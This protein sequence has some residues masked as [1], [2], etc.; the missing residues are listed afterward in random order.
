MQARIVGCLCGLSVLVACRTGLLT[1]MSVLHDKDAGDTAGDVTAPNDPIRVDEPAPLALE[2]ELLPA[3]AHGGIAQSTSRPGATA[4]YACLDGYRLVGDPIRTCQPDRTW[5]GR[6]AVCCSSDETVCD[7]RCVDLQTDNGNCGVCGIACAATPPSSAQC[8]DGRCL[9][10]LA[11]GQSASEIAVD[12]NGIYWADRASAAIKQL[13]PEGGTPAT[14]ATGQDD[15][16]GITVDATDLYWVSGGTSS[17]AVRRLALAGGHTPDTLLS[18]TSRSCDLAVDATSLYWYDYG[19]LSLVKVPLANN[20]A[21]TVL[22]K[23][24]VVITGFDVNGVDIYWQ[25]G[26]CVMKTDVAGDA[27]ATPVTEYVFGLAGA[28]VVA[29]STYAYMFC[30][31]SSPVNQQAI[32]RARLDDG[33][34]ETLT[35]LQQ[36]PGRLA[37]DGTSIFW[38][39]TNDYGTSGSGSSP[40]GTVMKVPKEGGTPETLLSGQ[41]HPHSVAVDDTSIYWITGDAIM[42]LT[43]K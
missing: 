4:R 26:G 19:E 20:A 16:C 28:S 30:C 33:T 35:P 43:P 14:L 22:R 17:T 9:T 13:A 37:L 12:K 24:D 8:I 29:D 42:K 40:R 23:S 3:P 27:P 1:P 15:P 34:F 31:T 6:P 32:L 5:S 2:C 21:P 25:E 18:G 36:A 38:T 11:T 7:D 10:T 39:S 41:D